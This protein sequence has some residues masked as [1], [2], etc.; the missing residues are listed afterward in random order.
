M[1][2]K[3]DRAEDALSPE[4][5]FRSWL[6]HF[7]EYPPLS[8]EEEQKLFSLVELGKRA[9]SELAE[10]LGV[11]PGR[12][13]LF[14]RKKASQSLGLGWDQPSEQSEDLSISF[15]S[16]PPEQ[17]RNYA[18]AMEGEKARLQILLSNV[19]LAAHYVGKILWKWPKFSHD[20][21]FQE[22]IMAID[23]AIDRFEV[24][25]GYKFSTYAI[26]W[27]KDA[28]KKALPKYGSS[29]PKGED[30]EVAFSVSLDDV[31]GDFDDIY[32]EDV[33]AGSDDIEYLEKR[34][35]DA[36]WRDWGRALLSRLPAKEAYVIGSLY[37]IGGMPVRSLEELASL[38]G[39]SLST[40]R[41]M[42][43]QAIESIR[44][45]LSE[46]ESLRKEALNLIDEL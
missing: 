39:V 14:F 25:R 13:R 41:R 45:L 30:G 28:M 40:V 42:K 29:L 36:R 7:K 11:E 21:L 31:F 16:L 6:A 24:G 43:K 8:K 1:K 20:D 15:G 3:L 9:I 17:K 44:R 22:A 5:A 23:T 35:E 18:M 34:T 38:L 32:W 27:F 10:H 46:D 33:I 37:G 12:L 4:Q 26:W 2:A 19:R